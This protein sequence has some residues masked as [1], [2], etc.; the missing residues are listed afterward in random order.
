MADLAEAAKTEKRTIEREVGESCAALMLV[1][2]RFMFIF[3]LSI[4]CSSAST[5]FVIFNSF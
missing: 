1:S 3:A 2:K 4:M 5:S